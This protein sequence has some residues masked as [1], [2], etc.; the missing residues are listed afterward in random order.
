MSD[1]IWRTDSAYDFPLLVKN[2]LAAP[3]VDDPEQEIVYRG[4]LRFTYRQFRERVGRLAAALLGLGVGPGDTVAVMDWDSHRYLE[5]F[6]AVPMIG[7]VLHT[8]NVRLSPEQLVYTMGHAED[9][10]LLDQRRA[11]APARAHQEPHRHRQA[12]SS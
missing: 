8:V 11:P 1:L 10:V 6:F 2:M 9:D 7:A 12:S 4:E 5:C 3:L